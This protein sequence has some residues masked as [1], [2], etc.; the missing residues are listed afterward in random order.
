MS[1]ATLFSI[2]CGNGDLY[3]AKEL[4]L[5]YSAFINISEYDELP[6]RLACENGHL[7]FAQW[8]LSVE[9]NINI[10][11]YE[12][13]F[14]CTCGNGHLEVAQWLLS[15][16]PNINISSNS[17][18]AFRYACEYGHLKVEQWL[19]SLKPY[20][21]VIKNIKNQKIKYYI[22]TKEE[23]KWEKIKNGLWLQSVNSNIIG[24]LPIDISKTVLMFC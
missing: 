24:A 5:R 4:L 2:A 8:L 21:Y 9:P 6:F 14:Y 3:K 17:N 18:Y 16:K 13:A 1:K 7:E 22:R 20:L 12:C 23:A 15:L 10:S 19:Q 11:I